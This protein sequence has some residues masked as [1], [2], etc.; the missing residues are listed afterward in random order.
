MNGE[1]MIRAAGA[2]CVEAWRRA[3]D[4]VAAGGMLLGWPRPAV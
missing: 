3:L 1:N 2:T 4:R